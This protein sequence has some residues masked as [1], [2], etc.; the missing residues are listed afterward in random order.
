MI[1][2]LLP[3]LLLQLPLLARAQVATGDPLTITTPSAIEICIASAEIVI[4]G[5]TPPYTFAV[6]QGATAVGT[7]LESF[8]IAAPGMVPWIDDIAEEGT[9]ISFVVTDFAGATESSGTV[10]V[11][12]TTVA[13]TAACPNANA[14]LGTAA[15]TTSS[16]SSTTSSSTTTQSTTTSTTDSTTTTT[17]SDSTTTSSP[18]TTTSLGG[19][20]SKAPNVFVDSAMSLTPGML[21]PTLSAEK[22]DAQST[23]LRNQVAALAGV[24]GMAFLIL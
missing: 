10:V 6:Y 11:A 3:V 4:A 2:S 14:G 5:G 19:P 9:E 18:S 22:A 1:F 17:T 12:A 8:T 13:T 24:A 20:Q 16:T 15:T 23:G 21:I 7:P